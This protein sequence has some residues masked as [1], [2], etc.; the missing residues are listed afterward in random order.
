ML[1]GHVAGPPWAG[2]VGEDYGL[3]AITQAKL[4]RGVGEVRL[5]GGLADEQG[6]GDLGVG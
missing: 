5:D 3:G 6:R 4:G 1:S 2:F